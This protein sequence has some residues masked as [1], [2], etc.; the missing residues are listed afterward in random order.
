MY[1]PKPQTSQTAGKRLG[2]PARGTGTFTARGLVT[3][4]VTTPRDPPRDP[5]RRLPATLDPPLQITPS[6]LG[7]LSGGAC[8][9]ALSLSGRGTTR[10]EHAQGTPTQMNIS[11]SILAYADNNGLSFSLSLAISLSPLRP[12]PPAHLFSKRIRSS[13]LMTGSGR[14][15]NRSAISSRADVLCHLLMSHLMSSGCQV[16]TDT[17]PDHDCAISSIEISLTGRF[18][19]VTPPRDHT[20]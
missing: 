15:P 9:A 7:V 11:S 20:S 13:Y 4:L 12:P 6:R 5:P 14:V 3:R 18:A 17:T 1:L 8:T 10:A 2:F 16:A 19:P